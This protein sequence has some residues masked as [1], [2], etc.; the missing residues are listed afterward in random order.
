MDM[1]SM[2]SRL[3]V[4]S[5]PNS[6]SDPC[7]LYTTLSPSSAPLA[8]WLRDVSV[9]NQDFSAALPLKTGLQY[10]DLLK[11][12]SH[13]K[14]DWPL[15]ILNI[16]KLSMFFSLVPP[17]PSA[18]KSMEAMSGSN[19]TS[20]PRATGSAAAAAVV[21][22][23]AAAAGSVTLAEQLAMAVVC[24]LWQVLQSEKLPCQCDCSS[25]V[26]KARAPQDTHTRHS[27]KK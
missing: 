5:S 1:K 13:F 4:D 21:S 23:I 15:F 18:W 9:K 14:P 11:N 6:A 8:I 24:I 10:N 17:S 2:G 26:L 7:E 20:A 19:S 16:P 22:R 27:W 25:F 3:D 12:L